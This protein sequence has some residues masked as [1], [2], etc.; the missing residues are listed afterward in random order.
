MTTTTRPAP[1]S[2]MRRR[3]THHDRHRPARQAPR[4]VLRERS[5]APARQRPPGRRPESGTTTARAHRPRQR[6]RRGRDR[7]HRLAG[8]PWKPDVDRARPGGHPVGIR[9]HRHRG[10]PRHRSAADRSAGGRGTRT[11]QP[12]GGAGHDLQ[13]R[14][15]RGRAGVDS[16]AQGAEP[17]GLHHARDAVLR[18]RAEGWR[19]ARL[20]PGHRLRRRSRERDEQLRQRH[21]ARV[22]AREGRGPARAGRRQRRRGRRR[23]RRS[24]ADDRRRIRRPRRDPCPRV[25]DGPD[26]AGELRAGRGTSG[27][28]K[29]LLADGSHAWVLGRIIDGGEPELFVDSGTY[30]SLEQF[31]SRAAERYSSDTGMR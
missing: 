12:H 27:A 11:P 30:A 9:P 24:G 10:S 26:P 17:D 3:G 18:T 14:G 25:D 6:R 19:P 13:A 2:M 28:A 8:L 4:P 15:A 23:P 20:R 21:P 31:A 16:P 5:R 7:G 29:V 1:Y 22:A